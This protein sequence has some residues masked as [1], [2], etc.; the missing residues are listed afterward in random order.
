VTARA[1]S[2]SEEQREVLQRCHDAQTER[3]W[4]ENEAREA[5]KQAR[6]VGIGWWTIAQAMGVGRN[7]VQRLAR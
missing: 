6:E 2:L 4:W 3:Q 5:V 1:A 7:R